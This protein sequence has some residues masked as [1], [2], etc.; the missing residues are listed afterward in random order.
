MNDYLLLRSWGSIDIQFATPLHLVLLSFVG[1]CLLQFYTD[2]GIISLV[3]IR[4]NWFAKH[5]RYGFTQN[6]ACNNVAK[7]DSFT[8]VKSECQG[9][10][11]SETTADIAFNFEFLRTKWGRIEVQ[12]FFNWMWLQLIITLGIPFFSILCSLTGC[13]SPNV[14]VLSC[15]HSSGKNEWNHFVL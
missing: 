7:Y 10:Y 4:A 6:T 13:S 14:S 11:A 2:Y 5:A 9:S 1:L 15:S 3:E 12:Q 8:A